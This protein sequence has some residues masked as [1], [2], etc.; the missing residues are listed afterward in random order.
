[1]HG[2][3]P[4]NWEYAD[5]W[6]LYVKDYLGKIKLMAKDTE[7]IYDQ[8]YG[9]CI[10]NPDPIPGGELEEGMTKCTQKVKTNLQPS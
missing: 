3:R 8:A 4:A 6:Q 7:R 9:S 1:M 2:S 10:C 5:L